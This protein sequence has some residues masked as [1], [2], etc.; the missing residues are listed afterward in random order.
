MATKLTEAVDDK[1]RAYDSP[2]CFCNLGTAE[3]VRCRESFH[4]KWDKLRLAGGNDCPRSK[5]G[6]YYVSN[7]GQGQYLDNIYDTFEEIEK[8]IGVSSGITLAPGRKTCP[9][10]VYVEPGPFWI[11]PIRMHLLSCIL[12]DTQG[13]IN[14]MYRGKY[15]GPTEGAFKY[16]LEGNT[17]YQSYEFKGWHRSFS[18]STAERH[19]LGKKPSTVKSVLVTHNSAWQPRV[20]PLSQN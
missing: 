10:Y 9:G 8:I 7:T 17:F 15:I 2:G 16:F 19:L 3:M 6:F 1:V 18:E 4:D 14:S 5:D 11:D 12:K 13:S 20:W